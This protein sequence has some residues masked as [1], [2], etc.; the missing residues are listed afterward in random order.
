MSTVY[1]SRIVIRLVNLFSASLLGC[2]AVGILYI[3][4]SVS[5]DSSAVNHSGV[6]FPVGTLE[7]EMFPSQE[8]MRD[9][10]P[11]TSPAQ[12]AGAVPSFF[13]FPQPSPL[14]PPGPPTPPRLP[15]IADRVA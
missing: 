12:P 9:V 15:L 14:S 7:Q 8:M 6:S 3:A 1:S 13:S 5:S 10:H 2:A 4:C 11:F